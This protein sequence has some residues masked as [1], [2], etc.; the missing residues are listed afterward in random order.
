MLLTLMGFLFS[1]VLSTCFAPIFDGQ[2]SSYVGFVSYI[3]FTIVYINTE[4]SVN[5]KIPLKKTKR[6]VRLSITYVIVLIAITFGLVVLV[7]YITFV[8][9]DRMTAILRYSLLSLI[10]STSSG[11]ISA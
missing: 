10:F 7:N 5:V 6:M 4:A 2:I 11:C 9:G 3:L 8:I 1:L